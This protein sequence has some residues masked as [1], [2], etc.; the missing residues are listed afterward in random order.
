MSKKIVI[1]LL[2]C[3]VFANLLLVRSGIGN[4]EGS[5]DDPWG[6]GEVLNYLFFTPDPKIEQDVVRLQQDLGLSNMQMEKLKELG[7]KEHTA[8]VNIELPEGYLSAPGK[9]DNE[10]ETK[11]DAVF[12]GIDKET[13]ELLSPKY[14]DFRQWVTEWWEKEKSY[15]E[16]WFEEQV[17]ILNEQRVK[18]NSEGEGLLSSSFQ[19][20]PQPMPPLSPQD[21]MIRDIKERKLQEML[22]K[23]PDP[24]PFDVPTVNDNVSSQNSIT[25]TESGI[26]NI[27]L[28]QQQNS[29]YC[30]PAT[31][32]ELLDYDWGYLST[33]SK[34]SQDE[35]AQSTPHHL[36]TTTDG[37]MVYR[38][39]DALNYL[40]NPSKSPLS[41]WVSEYLSQDETTAANRIYDCVK[42]AVST[43]NHGV[44]YRVNTC[45][46]PGQK[47]VWDEYYGLTGYFDPLDPTHNYWSTIHYVAGRGY[48]TY[49]NGRHRITYLDSWNHAYPWGNPYGYHIIDTRNVATC[50]NMANPYPGWIIW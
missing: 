20:G 43:E 38:I 21:R 45:P 31:T 37:T 36:Y 16:E 1:I 12:A 8:L 10:L 13:R 17:R 46:K 27:P 25:T 28:R 7:L 5:I 26:L 11:V 15:R 22:S 14:K 41:D 33:Q 48:T 39:T 3:V 47:D 42:E 44:V 30:G 9:L 29:Y 40:R 6:K 24:N 4:V 49:S 35:L 32:Q 19:S 2:V 23:E 18:N 50:V 34:Y